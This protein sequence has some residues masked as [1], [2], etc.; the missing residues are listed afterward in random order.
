[1]TPYLLTGYFDARYFALPFFLLQLALVV[2][3]FFDTG[4]WRQSSSVGAVAVVLFPTVACGVMALG[5]A[6]ISASA[7]QPSEGKAKAMVLQAYSCHLSEPGRRF[8][9]GGELAF[10]APRYGALTGLPTAFLPSNYKEMSEGARASYLSAM[11]PYRLMLTARDIDQC[12]QD[13]RRSNS[14]ADER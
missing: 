9:F 12:H 7:K 11:T 13:S 2:W 10:I 4:G 5:N 3:L 14:K 6:L 8:I 1:M